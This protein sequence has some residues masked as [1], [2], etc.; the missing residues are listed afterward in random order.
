[1]EKTVL[2]KLAYIF[3]KIDIRKVLEKVYLMPSDHII[4]DRKSVV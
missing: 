3:E 1:M 4:K 2:N